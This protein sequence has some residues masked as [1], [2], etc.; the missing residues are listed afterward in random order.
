[1][2]GVRIWFRI[3]IIGVF[4]IVVTACT[5]KAPEAYLVKQDGSRVALVSVIVSTPN[6]SASI[7]GPASTLQDQEAIQV[8][9]GE[10]LKV[11]VDKNGTIGDLSYQLVIDGDMTLVH[12]KEGTFTAPTDPGTYYYS[13][14]SKVLDKTVAYMFAL[15]V[16]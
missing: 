11:E 12:Q 5:P 9:P 4:L 7:S 6:W 3:A 10:N 16:K 8:V 2:K 1:M 14:D 15:Q 13:F